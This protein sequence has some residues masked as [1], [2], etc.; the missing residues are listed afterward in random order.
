M[1]KCKQCGNTC[2][3]NLFFCPL[4][5]G[6]LVECNDAVVYS[7][8]EKGGKV[9][10]RK[11]KNK[12]TREQSSQ[13]QTSGVQEVPGM[14]YNS[15]M[16]G[17]WSYSGMSGEGTSNMTETSNATHSTPGGG[18]GKRPVNKKIIAIAS[19]AV[20]VIVAVSIILYSIFGGNSKPEIFK[21]SSSDKPNNIID[22]V[23]DVK[24]M[25][26]D[27]ANN[28]QNVSYDTDAA[29]YTINYSE[30]PESFKSLQSGDTFAVPSIPDA[31]DYIFQ[32]GFSGIVSS[33]NGNSITFFVPEFDD[34]FDKISI[35]SSDAAVK[36]VCFI[37]EEGVEIEGGSVGK[38]HA[39]SIGLQK[40]IT[41]EIKLG[42][43]GGEFEYKKTNKESMLDDY[44]LLGEELKLK[45]NWEKKNKETGKKHKLTG[46]VS[47]KY[48]A[49]KYGL[50][51]DQDNPDKTQYTF[52]FLSEESVSIKYQYEKSDYENESS[53]DELFGIVDIED[54]TDL[55]KQKII[56][57]QFLIGIDAAFLPSAS[58]KVPF[59]IGILFQV[60]LNLKGEITVEAEAKQKGFMSIGVNSNG[61]NSFSIKS[62]KYPKAVLG[63]KIDPNQNY[64]NPGLEINVKGEVNG[65]IAFCVDVGFD[66]LGTLPIKVSGEVLNWELCTAFKVG[67][68]L[69]LELNLNE[70][71]DPA[72]A[73]HVTFF[74]S[75]SQCILK[76]NFGLNFGKKYED[77]NKNTGNQ[78]Q[79][80]G[81]QKQKERKE[82]KKNWSVDIGKFRFEKLLFTVV[83]KQFPIPKKFCREECDFGGVVLGDSYTQEEIN[84]TYYDKKKE[85]DESDLID[86]AK[87]KMLQNTL[88]KLIDKFGY[89]INDIIDLF[90]LEDDYDMTCFSD[91]TIYLSQNGVV[92]GA[93]ISGD[94]VYNRSYISKFSTEDAIRMVYSQ[95]QDRVSGEVSI[96]IAGTWVLETIG[97]GDLAN[98]DGVN[99]TKMH[100]EADDGSNMNIYFGGED[101]ICIVVYMDEE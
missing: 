38:L 63:E 14:P 67:S 41:K 86:E 82:K 87:D 8:S 11:K 90:P 10:K 46:S 40:A 60:G 2:D 61:N 13:T 54:T 5:Y 100:Y 57:G 97:L 55:E 64:D 17:D 96:G 19:G 59:G 88:Q 26:N 29:E 52:D 78:Q 93:L 79:K 48:P 22:F 85:M 9:P 75:K 45:I 36:N 37:P 33:V 81:E 89:S 1:K 20:A 15:A 23:D 44:N 39:A 47:F 50:F 91:G 94:Y 24:V 49:V 53:N 56:L 68:D 101:I 28:V 98:Y 58:N 71:I 30:L 99:L 27:T 6:E 69:K 7:Q 21:K 51:A 72:Q 31:N 35:N 66:C 74:Q 62:E 3:D 83:W 34:V 25:K 73:R 16:S 76:V 95:P 42:N 65:S 12:K 18:G 80:S 43:F 77:E 84:K 4:C 92:K 70:D 32:L